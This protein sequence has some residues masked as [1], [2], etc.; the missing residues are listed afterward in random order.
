MQGEMDCRLF[1]GKGLHLFLYEL[2]TILTKY[3]G[4]LPWLVE[5]P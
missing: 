2:L 5:F 1:R 4:H 3:G